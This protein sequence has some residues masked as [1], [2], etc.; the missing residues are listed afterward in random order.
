MNESGTL[1]FVVPTV[2]GRIRYY[3]GENYE[4]CEKRV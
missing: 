4:W 1:D 3:R 2:S